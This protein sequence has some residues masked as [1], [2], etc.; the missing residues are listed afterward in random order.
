MA[1]TF[2]AE[3][4]ATSDARV[5]DFADFL[6]TL[7]EDENS[8]AGALPAEEEAPDPSDAEAPDG[9]D[10]P[11]DPAIVPPVSWGEDAAELFRP[12]FRRRSRR[13]KPSANEPYRPR[14]PR[15]RRHGATP[16]PRPMRCSRTSSVSMP[17]IWKILPRK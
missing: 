13:A 6:D 14:P 16:Q 12:N 11:G 3:T 8:A 2:E 15:R 7:D 1:Q 5:E 9:A 10:E 17:T 4:P